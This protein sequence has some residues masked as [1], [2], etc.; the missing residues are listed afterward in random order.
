MTCRSLI[1]VGVTLLLALSGVAC[2]KFE[3]PAAIN[4]IV[5]EP[6]QLAADAAVAAPSCTQLCATG[7]A[8]TIQCAAGETAICDC[9]KEPRAKCEAGPVLDTA[10]P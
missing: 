2:S 8:T 5:A 1:A 7:V 9:N 3:E 4:A 6:E 10:T